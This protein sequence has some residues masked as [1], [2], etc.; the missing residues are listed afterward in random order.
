MATTAQRD[1]INRLL[2]E[3]EFD[4][5]RI[6]LAH[7]RRIPHCTEQWVGRTVDMWVDSLGK[8]EAGRVIE[9]LQEEVS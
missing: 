2:A 7:A 8:Y 1:L 5:A 6:T 3:A 4:L 9:F